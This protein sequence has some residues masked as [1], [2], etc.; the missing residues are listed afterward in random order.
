MDD[1]SLLDT[2]AR[3]TRLREG[4]A[5]VAAVLRAVF[6]AGS[7][8]L[9]DA[10]REARLPLPVTTAIRRELEKEGLL[11]RKHG[12][13]LSARGRAFVE[14]VLGLGVTHD[15]TCPA[16]GGRGIVIAGELRGAVA[17][18]AA[19]T[20]DAPSV[21]VTLDQCPCTPETAIL[22]A[23]LMQKTGALEG[24]RVLILGDD[25]SL[26]LAI[27]LVGHALGRGDLTRGVTVIESDPRRVA[28][29]REAAAREAI[30]LRLIEHD[31]RDPLP[32]GIAHAFDT[33]ATDPPYTLAGAKLFLGRAAAAL[34]GDG[35]CFLSFTRW[36]AA[37]LAELQ[38]V[39]LELGFALRA[40]H[41]GF[42][43]YLGASVLG[44]VGDLFEL[45]QSGVAASDP[46]RWDG[47]LY[48]AEVNPRERVYVCAQ[49]G[50]EIVLGENGA[51]ATIEAL[52]DAGCRACGG[53]IFRRRAG[54]TARAE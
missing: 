32:D 54:E 31:L 8:R 27:G 25:D 6:R 39:M 50:A 49:C 22:R 38:R 9:Q 33:V 42:N 45:V 35:T 20:A 23:L 47:P 48:T 2:V 53:K 52:K 18:L 16:C 36:P 40:A 43:R 30:A 51:P 5:G 19:L 46:P 26:S 12:L 10:A 14:T 24:R 41:P 34:N 3:A 21:D 1:V 37:Q 15:V 13:A 17:R 11:E 28:F 4:P 44:N 7:L 29:L